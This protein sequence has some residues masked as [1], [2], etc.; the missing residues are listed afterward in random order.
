MY[1]CDQKTRAK[2]P[3]VCRHPPALCPWCLTHAPHISPSIGKWTWPGCGF[4]VCG[5]SV[6][7]GL[8]F[9]SWLVR[10]VDLPSILQRKITSDISVTQAPTAFCSNMRLVSTAASHHLIQG[11][12]MRKCGTFLVALLWLTLMDQ[13]HKN[14]KLAQRR[15]SVS[16]KPSSLQEVTLQPVIFR[17]L[18]VVG[19]IC[20]LWSISQ[21]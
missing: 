10:I 20:K 14:N 15:F 4:D 18:Y 21:I 6:C 5:S 11:W 2:V 7:L 1:F 9:Y 17:A 8:R 16:L 19:F 3:V 13:G 12:S